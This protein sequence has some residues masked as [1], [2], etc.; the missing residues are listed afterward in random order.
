M[1]VPCVDAPWVGAAT[2]KQNAVG[3]AATQAEA[4]GPPPTAVAVQHPWPGYRLPGGHHGL[5]ALLLVVAPEADGAVRATDAHDAAA[6]ELVELERVHRL[7]GST[8]GGVGGARGGVG[9]VGHVEAVE[10]AGAALQA[11]GP[12]VHGRRAAVV[13]SGNQRVK[14]AEVQCGGALSVGLNCGHRVLQPQTARS[15]R[16]PAAL[17]DHG[18]PGHAVVALQHRHGLAL[19][20]PRRHANLSLS[21]VTAVLRKQ[22]TAEAVRRQ[23]VDH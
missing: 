2:G 21:N 5:V 15:S 18:I 22:R 7:H 13:D 1:Q 12:V 16:G 19:D 4:G 3:A 23:R 14:G 9:A 11:A 8:G 6:V 17:L 20:N 10:G